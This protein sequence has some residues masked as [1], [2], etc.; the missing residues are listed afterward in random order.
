M[1]DVLFGPKATFVGRYAN[2]AAATAGVVALGWDTGGAPRDGMFYFD[3]TLNV[4][5]GWDS[6]GAAW[7]VMGAGTAP[8]QSHGEIYITTIN[9]TVALAAGTPKVL[10]VGMTLN[11]VVSGFSVTNTAGVRRSLNNVSGATKKVEVNASLSTYVSSVPTSGINFYLYK[12]AVN[13]GNSYLQKMKHPGTGVNN[14]ESVSL[15]AILSLANNE[16]VEVWALSP[17][18]TTLTVASLNL[19]AVEIL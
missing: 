19:S 12:N 9:S 14:P 2:D 3:T 13:I 16:Y 10:D 4:F 18:A 15:S 1:A 5:K 17:G 7:V 11:A 8:T 6:G